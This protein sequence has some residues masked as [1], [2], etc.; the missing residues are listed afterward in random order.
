MNRHTGT[1]LHWILGKHIVHEP[2]ARHV[3]IMA[4]LSTHADAIP[5]ASVPTRSGLIFTTPTLGALLASICQSTSRRISK[6]YFLDNLWIVPSRCT[7]SPRRWNG[8]V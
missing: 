8:A 7:H 3:H 4:G 1:I 6:Y 2:P 5:I